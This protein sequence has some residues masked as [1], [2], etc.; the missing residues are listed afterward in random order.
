MCST[1]NQEN[2]RNQTA[3]TVQDEK[4][5]DMNNWLP[6]TASRKAKWWYSAFHNVTAIVGA[7]VLGM[8]F[9]L[10][11]LGWIP[12]V[13]CIIISWLV[14]FYTF[15][16][17]VELHEVV[18]GKRF[19][20]YPELGQHVFGPKLG[21]WIVM[22]QQMLVQVAIDIVYMV[23]GGKSL[24][25]FADLVIP[26]LGDIRKTYFTIFFL[27]LQ[28]VL[29]QTPNFNS[30]RGISLIAAVMSWS[31]SMVAFITS[32]IRGSKQHPSTYGVRSHTTAGIILDAFSGLGTIAF[33][34][35]GHSVALE[36]QATMPS[37]EETPSKKPMWR[38]VVVAYFIVAFCYVS[39]A[40]SGFWAFGDLV[41]DDVLISLERP[42]WL[43]A[44]ANFMVFLHV[45]GSYQVFAMPVFDGIESYVVQNGYFKPGRSLRLMARSLYVVSTGF[46]AICLPFFGGLLGFFGGLVFSSTSY[47]IPCIM[48]LVLHKPKRWSFHWFA[49]WFS[50]IIG[51]T[52]AVL[53]P[54]GG[55]RQIILSAKTY[56]LFS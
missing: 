55:I 11:Q 54:I 38:G 17:L 21:Y 1:Y 44:M 26:S 50:T 16:Q 25:K 27:V 41:E 33:A 30:L 13:L 31:Y 19:D 49:S 23:T 37:T 5:A 52:V 45:L 15:W 39:V 51:V 10:S 42:R 14:T 4:N 7:G 28:L 29:S 8:P 2:Y 12:G 35:A 20:R 53:A 3:S 34:F 40:V 24:K 56:K 32:I 47:F 22:P 36:I 48:W 43:I 6:I 9:A 18:P 46:V